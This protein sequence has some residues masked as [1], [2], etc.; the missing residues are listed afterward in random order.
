MVTR[1]RAEGDI[2]RGT[3]NAN[4]LRRCDRWL[5]AW[6]GLRTLTP[7]TVVDLGFGA[8]ITTTLELARR[9]A[10]VRPDAHVWGI[11]IDPERVALARKEIAAHMP[12]L[13][14]LHVGFGGFEIPLPGNV[15]PGIIRAFNVLRQ[16]DENQVAGAWSTMISRLHPQG[17][18]V[19]GTC[20]EIGRISTWLAVTPEGPQSLTVSLRLTGLDLPSIAAERLPKA[21]IHHNVPSQPIHHFFEDL[22]SA[23]R[24]HAGLNA[25]GAV[26]RWQAA[27]ES[28]KNSGWP[29]QGGRSR[30][31]LGE[32]TVAWDA[33]APSG[34]QRGVGD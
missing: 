16:Y 31:R 33:V 23:W 32:V 15:R 1:G 27:V 29:I 17:L 24:T 25:F 21:L 12:D 18:L 20:D 34:D 5:M 9:L 8:R 3:T 19:D 13:P 7:L 30:W 2:T 14:H 26:Q 22:D 4:R 6:P 28:L 11:E 10:P